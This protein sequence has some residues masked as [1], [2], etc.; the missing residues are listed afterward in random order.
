MA[1]GKVENRVA[2]PAVLCQ[3]ARGIE[4]GGRYSAGRPP[5]NHRRS[6]NEEA[7]ESRLVAWSLDPEDFGH[8]YFRGSKCTST[9]V[10]TLTGLPL[11]T[12]GL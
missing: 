10:L 8:F 6:T 2:F 5:A 4:P 9:S 1:S 7:V 12:V 11:L 3:G